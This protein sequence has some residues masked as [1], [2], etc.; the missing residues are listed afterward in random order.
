MANNFKLTNLVWEADIRPPPEILQQLKYKKTDVIAEL[1]LESGST[2]R[3][4]PY[5]GDDDRACETKNNNTRTPPHIDQRSMIEW[6]NAHFEVSSPDHCAWCHRYDEPDHPV[7]PFGI[8]QA[9][10]TWLHAECWRPWHERRRTMAL[11][12]LQQKSGSEHA[13]T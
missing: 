1:E 7:I 6:L 10:R 9:G 12:A 5:I 4:F 2:P 8:H 3:V 11:Q 13:Y